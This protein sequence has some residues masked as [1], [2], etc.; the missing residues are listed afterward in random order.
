MKGRRSF[1]N[2]IFGIG[3]QILTLALG[4]VIPRLFIITLG[5]EVNGLMSSITQIVIYLGLLEAGVGGASIQALYSP[6]SKDDKDGVNGI[7]A[8]TSQYYKKT[9]MWY[10]VAVLVF[11]I[12]YPF[13]ISSNL[14]RLEIVAVILLTGMS[15]AINFF[16]Q[17]KFKLL[18]TA[19]GKSYIIT[20]VATI[21][22]ILTSAA[23][24]ILLLL[25]FNIV[26]IQLSYFLISILQMIIIWF[27]IKRNYKWINLNVKPNYDAISQKNSVLVHQI[28]G[29]IFNNTDILVL[30]VYC[31]LKVVSVYV[32]YNMLFEIV[33]TAISNINSGIVF[34]L[35][36]SYYEDK[37][38]YMKLYDSYELYYMAVVFALYSIMYILI[39]PFIKLYTAGITDINYIDFWLPVLFVIL[40]LLLCARTPSMNAIN[41]SGHFRKTQYRSI[42]ES[43]INIVA[44]LIFVNIF[45]IYGV[46]MGTIVALLYRTN[47]I[48]IYSSKYILKR[49]PWITYR[50]WLVNL[51]I[52]LI[53]IFI[54]NKLHIAP[55]SYINIAFTAVILSIT[56]IPIFF[57]MG[58]IFE[59]RVCKYTFN[60]MRKYI[61]KFF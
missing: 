39:L 55:S 36:Q 31:G 49:T 26:L 35:G 17:G 1:Y 30:T 21:I 10:C 37:N 27:Y 48:I 14:N 19:E 8:A 53:I 38:K 41:V 33:N 61:G 20:I 4:I 46:L 18:L 9:G 29:L 52:S 11:A 42:F 58:S 59:I 3:G 13:F 23:K 57:I 6:I 5:S 22:T 44:S 16:F 2:I 40:K 47:D 25:G 34:V 28:S 24:I 50:R 32:M 43:T 12:I 60:Y 51:A 15:G 56:I 45:G 54:S 7:L